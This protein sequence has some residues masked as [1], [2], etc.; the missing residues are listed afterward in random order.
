MVPRGGLNQQRALLLAKIMRRS[1]PTGKQAIKRSWTA[2]LTCMLTAA[3]THAVNSFR[4]LKPRKSVFISPE[5]KTGEAVDKFL[6]KFRYYEDIP[7]GLYDGQTNDAT[8][9]SWG[10]N[11]GIGVRGDLDEDTVY[12]ITKAFWENLDSV[13][14]DAPWASVLNVKHSVQKLGLIDLH[15]GAARYYK[16]V[17]A[18]E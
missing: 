16:E 6:G 11:V 4:S 1:R 15:P 13:T 17:G 9:Q 3:W 10:T 7:A 2:R 18:I 8:S 5:D 12:Q 14:T